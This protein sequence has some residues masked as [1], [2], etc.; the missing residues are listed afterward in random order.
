MIA[1][2]RRKPNICADKSQVLTRQNNTKYVKKKYNER[3]N[4]NYNT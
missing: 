3:I 1:Q 4:E 2:Q